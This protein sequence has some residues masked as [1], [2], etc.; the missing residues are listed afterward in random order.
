[1]ITETYPVKLIDEYMEFMNGAIVKQGNLFTD[2]DG[3]GKI[4]IMAY[5]IY[6]LSLQPENDEIS[7][8][9]EFIEHLYKA[10]IRLEVIY[11]LQ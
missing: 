9:P 5:R 3:K 1:M 6:L 10:E 2:Y 11:C 8:T 7:L 4:S